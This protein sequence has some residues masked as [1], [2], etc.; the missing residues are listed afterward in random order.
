MKF[1]GAAPE[2]LN[3]IASELRKALSVPDAWVEVVADEFLGFLV[4]VALEVSLEEVGN[5]E[6]GPSLSMD[7]SRFAALNY[8]ADK[9][10]V[11]RVY[12]S[13]LPPDSEWW[14]ETVPF[15]LI[16]ADLEEGDWTPRGIAEHIA[17]LFKALGVTPKTVGA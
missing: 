2:A 1:M 8:V 9:G 3:M 16:L 17:H 12:D 5:A 4:Q 11:L 10:W 14:V 6:S 13:S 7:V 15:T